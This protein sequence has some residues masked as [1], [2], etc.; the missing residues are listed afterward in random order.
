MRADGRRASCAAGHRVAL[1][2]VLASA[3]A[4]PAR[5]DDRQLLQASS[6]AKMDVL[7]ILDSSSSMAREFSDRFDLP[8]S[9]DDFVYPEGTVGS[10]NGSKLGVAR[11]VLRQ[12]MTK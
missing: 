1:A 9:L 3:N 5:P 6:G 2:L 10:T 11:S 4:A 7:V 12:I 8:A